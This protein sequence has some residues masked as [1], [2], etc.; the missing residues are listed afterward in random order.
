[1]TVPDRSL[2]VAVDTFMPS[3][4]EHSDDQLAEVR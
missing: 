4:V 2:S 1:M 3:E